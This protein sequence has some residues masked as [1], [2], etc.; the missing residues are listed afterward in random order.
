MYGAS[1]HSGTRL[2]RN[3]QVSL[4][5]SQAAQVGVVFTLWC[6]SLCRRFLKGEA[7]IAAPRLGRC[8]G[9]SG[10]G[11]GSLAFGSFQGNIAFPQA[12]VVL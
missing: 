5:K 1:R 2:R 11:E 12:R 8:P 6:D 9:A 7:R 4:S 3:G 10:G